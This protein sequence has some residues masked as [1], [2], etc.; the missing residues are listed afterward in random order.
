MRGQHTHFLLAGVR[1][2]KGWPLNGGEGG[3]RDDV[4]DFGDGEKSDDY[5]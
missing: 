1:R 4:F 2:W 5:M 3:E